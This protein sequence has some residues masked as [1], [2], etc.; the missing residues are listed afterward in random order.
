MQQIYDCRISCW[1]SCQL[2]N[3][4]VYQ[5]L[6]ELLNSLFIELRVIGFPQFLLF[7]IKYSR[8]LLTGSSSKIKSAQIEYRVITHSGKAIWIVFE[9]QKQLEYFKRTNSFKL[10][11][12]KIIDFGIDYRVSSAE[13]DNLIKSIYFLDIPNN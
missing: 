10:V 11:F 12:G 4:S 7:T 9:Y 1:K 2:T 3:G 13:L 6:L 8:N 5:W